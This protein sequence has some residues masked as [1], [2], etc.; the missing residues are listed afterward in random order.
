M[1]TSW[2]TFLFKCHFSLESLCDLGVISVRQL[3]SLFSQFC[4]GEKRFEYE[5]WCVWISRNSELRACH[6]SRVA[7]LN[8]S[9]VKL[10]EHSSKTIATEV[11]GGFCLCCCQSWGLIMEMFHLMN[12]HGASQ[13]LPKQ[14]FQRLPENCSPAWLSVGVFLRHGKKSSV[15][16]LEFVELDNSTAVI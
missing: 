16:V 2:I 12:S 14:S 3:N 8:A 4:P 1:H 11:C 9:V 13:I 10:Q 7:F 5:Q 15:D 6:Q